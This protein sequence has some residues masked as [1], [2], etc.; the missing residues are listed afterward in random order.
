MVSINVLYEDEY[1]KV[2][3]KPAGVLSFPLPGSSEKTIGDMAKGLPVHRLDR[4]TSGIL[5]LA[6]NEEAKAAMQKLFKDRQIEKRYKALVWGNL[7]PAVGEINIP[8]GRGTKDRLR[9]VPSHGGRESVTQYSMEK[10][11]N[12]ANTSLI[13][14]NLKTGRTHQIRVHFNAIGHPVVGDKKYSNRKSN[15]SRQ[16]LHAYKIEF[17]HPYTDKKISLSSDLPEDLSDYLRELG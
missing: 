7:E 3:E 4:D 12:G 15:L 5:I 8:L 9:V 2:V 16:F 13:D 14:V 10:Y 17:K 11:F 1:L 6:K